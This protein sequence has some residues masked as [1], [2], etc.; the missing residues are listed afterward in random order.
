LKLPTPLSLL[1]S[2]NLPINLFGGS[3]LLLTGGSSFL[4]LDESVEEAEKGLAGLGIT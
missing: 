4:F 1:G 3:S 2:L